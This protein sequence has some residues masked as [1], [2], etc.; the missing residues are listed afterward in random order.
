MKYFTEIGFKIAW[1]FWG[2]NNAI[3]QFLQKE[4][5][6]EEMFYCNLKKYLLSFRQEERYFV[7]QCSVNGESCRISQQEFNNEQTQLFMWPI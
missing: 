7:R 3:V 6:D 2:M 5:M 1:I 4:W